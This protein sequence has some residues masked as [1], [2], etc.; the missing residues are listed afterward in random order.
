[1]TRLTVYRAP[2]VI[3]VQRKLQVFRGQTYLLLF[4]TEI[5]TSQDPV[6]YLSYKQFNL[7]LYISH[8]ISALDLAS[9]Y[10]YE[11]RKIEF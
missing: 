4:V 9:G 3:S 8:Y 7:I 10:A 2:Q 11:L 5:K 1:M 6:I